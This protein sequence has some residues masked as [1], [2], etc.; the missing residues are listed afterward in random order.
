MEM[1]PPGG[2]VAA[3]FPFVGPA[4]AEKWP[5]PWRRT[6]ATPSI[7][8]PSIGVA[9]IRLACGQ[10]HLVTSA[11]ITCNSSHAAHRCHDVRRPMSTQTDFLSLSLTFY[12]NLL[13]WH[14]ADALI[15]SRLDLFPLKFSIF[16]K[17]QLE[18]SG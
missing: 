16:P 9:N 14:S 17:F 1:A 6:Q 5:F 18:G 4:T 12:C 10:R 7:N 3:P 2:R 13:H 11:S 8:G 15:N